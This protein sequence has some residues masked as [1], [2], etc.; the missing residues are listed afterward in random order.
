MTEIRAGQKDVNGNFVNPTI[1]NNEGR[2][3][4]SG[5]SIVND[6]STCEQAQEHLAVAGEI[7]T[8]RAVVN[9]LGD[10][11][12]EAIDDQTLRSIA[13]AQPGQSGGMI[14]GEAIP[15]SILEQ[16]GATRIGR[17]GWKDRQPT[18]LSFASR[19]IP[20]RNRRYQ[21]FASA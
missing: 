10:G 17:F 20:E 2:N 1:L 6:R 5:R 4:I 3:V 12:V 8:Q 15:V 9:I 13:A 19:R 14:Q 16:P 7:R 11:F 18:V 21:P